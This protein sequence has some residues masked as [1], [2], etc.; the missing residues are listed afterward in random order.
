MF[1]PALAFVHFKV[2]KVANYNYAWRA[3]C[4]ERFKTLYEVHIDRLFQHLPYQLDYRFK[5]HCLMQLLVYI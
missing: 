5:L 4:P 2:V 1:I 3:V